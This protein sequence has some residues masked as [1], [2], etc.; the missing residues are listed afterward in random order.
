MCDERSIHKDDYSAMVAKLL[1]LNSIISD[2]IY[3]IDIEKVRAK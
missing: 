2:M 3:G 1:F